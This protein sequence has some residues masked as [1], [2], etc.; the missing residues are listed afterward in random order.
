MQSEH[1]QPL[2]RCSDRDRAVDRDTTGV[3]HSGLTVDGVNSGISQCAPDLIGIS[4]QMLRRKS[5][6]GSVISSSPRHK[7]LPERHG[8]FVQ[9]AMA[10]LEVEI[11]TALSHF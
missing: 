4:F 7:W 10:A 3:F 11:D 8:I 6:T 1:D 9:V 5:T 2:R